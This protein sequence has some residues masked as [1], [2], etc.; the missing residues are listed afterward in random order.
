MAIKKNILFGIFFV[1]F[2]TVNAQDILGLHSDNYAGVYSLGYNPAEIVDSRY[3]LHV[4]V[5][6]GNGT[7][8]SN[9]LGLRREAFFGPGQNLFDFGSLTTNISRNINYYKVQRLDVTDR[10]IYNEGELSTFPSFMINFGRK[11][12]HALAFSYKLRY[13]SAATGF[14]SDILTLSYSNPAV[15]FATDD[16]SKMTADPIAQFN[17]W[18]EYAVTYGRVLLNKGKHFISAAATLKVNQGVGGFI[19]ESTKGNI[20]VSSPTSGGLVSYTTDV[21][22]NDNIYAANST[23]LSRDG[24]GATRIL[25]NPLN[26]FNGSEFGVGADLGFVWEYRP[27]IESHRYK[28]DGYE[29]YLNPATEKYLFKVGVGIIDIGYV[30]YLAANG[31]NK[32]YTVSRSGIPLSDVISNTSG[33]ISDNLNF[34]GVSEFLSTNATATEDR[35][36]TFYSLLPTKFNVYVDY[37]IYKNFY[38]NASAKFAP[39]LCSSCQMR[40]LTEYA[41]TPRFEKKWFGVYLPISANSNRNGSIGLG[42]RAGPLVLGMR[43]VLPF[44]GRNQIYEANLYFGLS[45]PIYDTIKDKDGDHVS[46]YYD[47]CKDKKGPWENK[48]CPYDF[49]NDGIEDDVDMCP[50]SPGTKEYDGC[51]DTD[52]DKIHDGIDNCVDEP[53]EARFSG[54]P[55]TDKDGIPDHRDLCPN[56]PGL[57][58][59]EGCPDTDGDKIHDGIDDCPEIPGEERFGGCV[60]TDNDTIRDI[61]DKCPV[62]FGKIIYQGCPPVPPTVDEHFRNFDSNEVDLK[63]EYLSYYAPVTKFMSENP[64]FR[65]LI[66]GHTDA[67]A[68]IPYNNVVVGKQRAERAKSYLVSKGTSADRISIFSYGERRPIVSNATR[69]GRTRNRRIELKFYSDQWGYV[70]PEKEAQRV[71][72]FEDEE[73]LREILRAAYRKRRL[74]RLAEEKAAAEKQALQNKANKK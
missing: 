10:R 31:E 67:T 12:Q 45:V 39:F 48:G 65:L 18:N 25:E 58:E 26:V 49:D 74:K 69:E 43:D 28:L 15:L 3:K 53:G 11:K 73:R 38:L 23:A 40:S 21:N 7:I 63:P 27:N 68:A 2:T 16:D 72:K 5:F 8:S 60:D 54:C 41:V 24:G 62:V 9:Y 42:F 17:I 30:P 33:S 1:F 35:G 50:E 59:Y 64:E 19:A 20:A 34:T 36:R 14:L 37:N 44:F 70:Q 13:Q 71:K 22:I 32:Q 6:S 4:N 46:D 51:P 55:D 52:G 47:N 61:D 57:P 66:E 29:K 56:A